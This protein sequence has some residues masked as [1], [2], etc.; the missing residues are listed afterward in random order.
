KPTPSIGIAQETVNLTEGINT[1]VKTKGRHD[2]CVV[3]RAVPV[4]EALVAIGIL[5]LFL[6]EEG[7]K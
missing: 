6:E 4:V 1:I 7:I 3:P 2:P 5:D